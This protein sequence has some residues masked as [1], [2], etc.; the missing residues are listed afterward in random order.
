MDNCGV[1][2]TY[3]AVLVKD[4]TTYNR[5]LLIIKDPTTLD[6]ESGLTTNNL[7]LMDHG[8]TKDLFCTLIIMFRKSWPDL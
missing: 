7:R 4:K 2:N 1:E 6:I 3:I 8:L 5:N